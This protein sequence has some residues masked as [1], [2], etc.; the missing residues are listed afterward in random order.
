MKGGKQQPAASAKADSK[1]KA[2][3]IPLPPSMGDDPAIPGFSEEK[4]IDDLRLP[5]VPDISMNQGPT[6]PD[7]PQRPFDDIDLPDMP[8]VPQI[9]TPDLQPEEPLSEMPQEPLPT[10]PQPM[11]PQELEPAPPP[12]PPPPEQEKKPEEP[13]EHTPVAKMPAK[14]KSVASSTGLQEFYIKGEDYRELLI[15]LDLA[16][17]KQKERVAQPEKDIFSIEEKEYT[18]FILTVEDIHKRFMLAESILFEE[19]RET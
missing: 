5:E 6:I 7:Q 8:E 14:P 11:E 9:D 18:K 16:I 19:R 2:D 4:Q 17:S 10:Q 15:G 1:P 12:E 3:E 13:Y